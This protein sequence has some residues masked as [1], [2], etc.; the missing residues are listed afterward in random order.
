MDMT[1]SWVG[2]RWAANEADACPIPYAGL[3]R[4]TATGPN[5]PESTAVLRRTPLTGSPAAGAGYAD[6][7]LLVC[8]DGS[9]PWPSLADVLVVSNGRR[10]S[11]FAGCLVAAY[12]RP[13]GDHLVE[14][15]GATARLVPWAGDIRDV[16]PYVSFIHAWLVAGRPFDA[17]F[18]ACLKDVSGTMRISVMGR[19]AVYPAAS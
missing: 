9:G 7:H 10:R 8:G 11:T 3:R 17:L 12:G 6:E 18:G 19:Q 2:V 1:A 4:L 5:A 16:W 15:A 13:T 14:V